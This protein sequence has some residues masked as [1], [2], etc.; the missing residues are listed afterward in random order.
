[1]ILSTLLALESTARNT[2][3]R[4]V[5]VSVN[6][7][8]SPELITAGSAI[9]RAQASDLKMMVQSDDIMSAL[10]DSIINI[11]PTLVLFTGDLTHN[12]ERLSHERMAEHL[13][14]MA[15]QGIRALVIPGN[16][17]CNNPGAKRF[18]GDKTLPTAT[19]TREEFA[20]IYC[21]YGYGKDSR[22]D[23]ASLSYCC[24]PS[25]GLVIIAIDSNMDELN[26]LTSR[27][28][29]TNNYYSSGRI[30]PETLQWV[31]DQA[32]SARQQGKLVI[33]MM[34]HHLIPHFDKEDRPHHLH[35]APAR[36]RCCYTIQ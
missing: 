33:A 30:K 34:H 4:I 20:Q 12:G 10:T 11:K 22:R 24:E 27:G 1:M 17:D 35:G 5:V 19:V 6:H 14:R 18:D 16:H 23:P 25:K 9:E 32:S 8:L 28:D 2:G 26:T 21:D 7:L 29:S 36:D 15:E 13:G 3:E 31:I